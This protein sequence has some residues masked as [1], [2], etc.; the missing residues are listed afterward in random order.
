MSYKVKDEDA[1][2]LSGSSCL[3]PAAQGRLRTSHNVVCCMLYC[4]C[5][6]VSVSCVRVQDCLLAGG[7]D[8]VRKL[9]DIRDSSTWLQGTNNH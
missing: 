9:M 1:F 4:V 6:C 7:R 8:I 5:C 3:T 2:L